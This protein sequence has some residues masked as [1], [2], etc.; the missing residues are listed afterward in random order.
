VIVEMLLSDEGFAGSLC[1]LHLLAVTG[2][3][4]RTVDEYS[5]L[6]AAAGLKLTAVWATDALP[7]VLVG[8]ET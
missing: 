2:G 4:E 6:L 8:V 3:R 7:S 1:D 5:V